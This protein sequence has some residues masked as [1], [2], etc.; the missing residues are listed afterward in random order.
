MDTKYYY[1]TVSYDI[2]AWAVHPNLALDDTSSLEGPY[3]SAAERDKELFDDLSQ[4]DL[5]T[6]EI[7]NVM[8][9]QWTNDGLVVEKLFMADWS[10]YRSDED[11]EE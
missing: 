1:L 5:E 8:L 4:C 10:D 3:D 2:P 9:L 7:V 11:N 6:A